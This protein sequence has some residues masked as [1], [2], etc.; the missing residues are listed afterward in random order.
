MLAQHGR[1][2]NSRD[3]GTVHV[4]LNRNLADFAA[5]NIETEPQS[6]EQKTQ[7]LSI[8][9]LSSTSVF[10]STSQ[11][12]GITSSLHQSLKD[13]HWRRACPAIAVQLK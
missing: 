12:I 7:S 3:V 1:G 10:L 8:T 11:P 2:R 13:T 5:F 9:L 6:S 4:Y